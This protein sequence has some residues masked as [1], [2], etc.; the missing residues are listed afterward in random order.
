MRHGGLRSWALVATATLVVACG[1]TSQ[2]QSSPPETDSWEPLQPVDG[3]VTRL[4]VVSDR[5]GG[6][7]VAWET[8]DGQVS[9]ARWHDAQQV[10]SFPEPVALK[11]AQLVDPYG[12]GRPVLWGKAATSDLGEA[13]ANVALRFDPARDEWGPPQSLSAWPEPAIAVDGVGNAYVNASSLGFTVDGEVLWSWWPVAAQALP[14][15]RLLAA[16]GYVDVFASA[17]AGAWLLD[18]DAGAGVRGFDVRAGDWGPRSPS[19]P[20]RIDEQFHFELGRTGQIWGVTERSE[21]TQLVVQVQGYDPEL[22]VWQPKETALSTDLEREEHDIL[23]AR[24]FS[25]SSAGDTVV[26]YVPR[27]GEWV[28][29]LELSRRAA[30]T[31]VWSP[32]QVFPDVQ[33]TPG[34]DWFQED[35]SG[36]IYGYLSSKFLYCDAAGSAS[37]SSLPD[38]T[39]LFWW[40]TTS[41]GAFALGH[42]SGQLLAYRHDGDDWRPARGLPAI[43]TDAESRYYVL[44]RVGHDRALVV[45]SAPDGRGPLY[46]AFLE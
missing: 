32:L 17:A 28:Y 42:S 31:G 10:W 46:S 9:F 2:N 45:W 5:D 12:S 16:Y 35:E 39:P 27:Q 13:P 19:V 24:V 41:R 15:P 1:H 3:K 33:A 4:N 34:L 18:S 6:A 30:T 21:P 43:H 37:L 29:D 44:A 22:A 36:G 20:G 23:S 25:S 14:P 40:V 7:L 26:T 8:E 38:D 11:S